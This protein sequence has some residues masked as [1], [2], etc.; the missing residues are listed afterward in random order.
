MQRFGPSEVNRVFQ[1]AYVQDG[2]WT[3]AL[4]AAG[5]GWRSYDVNPKLD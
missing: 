4:D 5:S 2:A 1:P 3:L